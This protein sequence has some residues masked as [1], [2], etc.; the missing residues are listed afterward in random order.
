M[1]K[2]HLDTKPDSHQDARKSAGGASTSSSNS[3]KKGNHG[4]LYS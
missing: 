4:G 3:R 2:P 1:K